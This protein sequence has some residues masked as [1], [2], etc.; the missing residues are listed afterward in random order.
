MFKINMP[1]VWFVAM[2]HSPAH[3]ILSSIPPIHS[4][5]PGLSNVMLRA[6]FSA[7]IDLAITADCRFR[8]IAR[9]NTDCA[10][11]AFC[12]S[13]VTATGIAA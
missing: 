12:L 2:N 8:T 6:A 4:Q 3:F 11:D 5:Y 10:F 7:L 9:L 1:G 13:T